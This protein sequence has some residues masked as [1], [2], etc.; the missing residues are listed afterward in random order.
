MEELEGL[1]QQKRDNPDYQD[2]VGCWVES[3]VLFEK[4]SLDID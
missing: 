3:W 4:G 1:Q 2:Q